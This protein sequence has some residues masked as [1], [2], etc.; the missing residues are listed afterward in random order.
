MEVLRTA[1][2]LSRATGSWPSRPWTQALYWAGVMP[3]RRI[4]SGAPPGMT[5]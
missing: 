1:A 4:S 3:A 5:P 2:I